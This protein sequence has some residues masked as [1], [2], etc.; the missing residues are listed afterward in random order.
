MSSLNKLCE[1]T[2]RIDFFK[3]IVCVGPINHISIWLEKQA[4]PYR[5]Q[6]STPLSISRMEKRLHWPAP[7]QSPGSTTAWTCLYSSCEKSG[8]SHLTF[9]DPEF[10]LQFYSQICSC[11]MQSSLTPALHSHLTSL[12]TNF[13]YQLSHLRAGTESKILPFNSLTG[14]LGS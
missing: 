14:N 1:K 12:H 13:I 11:V 10:W 7:E 6:N 4:I 9:L 3:L 2:N 8:C 5:L